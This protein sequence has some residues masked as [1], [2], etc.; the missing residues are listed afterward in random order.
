LCCHTCV[1]TQEK[2]LFF[3]ALTS[4]V[5][6]DVIFVAE[7]EKQ[8]IVMSSKSTSDKTFVSLPFQNI[9]SPYGIVFNPLDDRIYWTDSTRGVVARS[10]IDG[11]DQEDINWNLVRPLGIALDLVGGNVYWIS[12]GGH[13]I[14]VSKL[15]G[16]Y[17]KVLVSNLQSY[18]RDITLDTKRGYV[19]P[20]GDLDYSSY[21]N[22]L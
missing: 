6:G 14:E 4:G 21:Q 5:L 17:W 16:D 22:C 10:S 19:C 9:T 12:S 1:S 3:F 11:K 18:A 2:K 20:F 13:T 7:K 15:N 8:A